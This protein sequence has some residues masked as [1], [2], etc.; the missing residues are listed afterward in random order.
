MSK[1]IFCL[2]VCAIL[3]ALCA[4]AQAQQPKKVPHVGVLAGGSAS[5]DADRIEALRQGL[6]EL[7]YVEGKNIVIE[8][9]YERSRS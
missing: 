6:R 5:S 7:G 9:E 1:K 2:A 8:Y 4:C 3:L